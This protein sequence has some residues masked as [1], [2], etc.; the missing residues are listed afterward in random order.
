M[1]R[2]EHQGYIRTA[3]RF[4]NKSI[5]QICRESGHS[6]QTV[7]KVLRSEPGG[8]AP[9]SEQAYPVSGPYLPIIDRWLEEE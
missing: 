9:R 8:Y 4:Y 2:M 3:Y 7:R 6:R 1:I 5:K